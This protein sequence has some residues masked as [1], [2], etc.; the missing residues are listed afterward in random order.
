[1]QYLRNQWSDFKKFLK[2]LNP[3]TSPN[4]TVYNVATA[5]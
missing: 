2:L 1:M 5:P 4:L 3:D